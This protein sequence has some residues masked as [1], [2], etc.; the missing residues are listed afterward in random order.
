MGRGREGQQG[1][2]HGRGVGWPVERGGRE[3][4]EL[5]QAAVN[6]QHAARGI[7]RV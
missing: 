1:G 4:S 5:E 6:T 7:G 3:G 2:V